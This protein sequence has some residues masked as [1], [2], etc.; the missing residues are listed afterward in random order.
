M[1]GNGP[2]VNVLQELFRK[3]AMHDGIPAAS[4]RI[5]AKTLIENV[6]VFAKT[7]T[8]E[9][10]D[11]P[12]SNHVIIFDEAQRAWNLAQNLSKFRRNY[13]EPEMLLKIMERHQD[14]AVVIALVGG[15]QEIN[16]GEAGLEEWGAALEQ[17][18]FNWKVFASPEVIAGGTSTAGHK[19]FASGNKRHIDERETLHLRTSNRNLRADNF[20]HW[21]NLVLDGQPEQAAAL[22]VTFPVFLCRNLEQTRRTL[23]L[24]ALADSRFGLVGSSKAARLRPE[25][26][27]HD[28][29]FHGEYPW[30]HWYLAPKTDI[31]S[32]YACEVFA[33]EFSIQGLE[34]DWIGLCWGGDFVW[35]ESAWVA[36]QLRH[37]DFTKWGVVRDPQKQIYRRN[38]YRVLLT[39][40]RQ[41][42]VI[43][44]P[45]GDI[46]DP[47]RPPLELDRTAD[48]L[49]RCGVNALPETP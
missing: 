39:R 23:K 25:G 31:R 40:A 29:T 44:V 28:S 3:Q 48:Y 47:T 45:R 30:H 10:L 34:L 36:R 26:L 32:S 12:P 14:W 5:Q 46:A 49:I 43:Y 13:S 20:S 18:Q 17:S 21:V 7:Y 6:H 41:G 11:R 15:G 37:G 35:S 24:E 22:R 19:L 38:S 42:I 16:S 1:S 4:A 27:E 2:L 8:D 33:S 9:D